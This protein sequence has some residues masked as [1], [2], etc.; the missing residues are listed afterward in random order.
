MSHQYNIVHV[1]YDMHRGRRGLYAILMLHVLLYKTCHITAI[2]YMHYI[3]FHTKILMLHVLYDM[4][5]G[6]RYR[7]RYI[8]I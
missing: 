8:Y 6:R 1:L 4:H 7:Y 2:Y 5:R 3:V